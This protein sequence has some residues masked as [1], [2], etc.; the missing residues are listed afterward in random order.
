MAG[1]AKKVPNMPVFFDPKQLTDA[2]RKNWDAAIAEYARV[3][4]TNPGYALEQSAQDGNMPGG[5]IMRASRSALFAR[6]LEGK[7]ALPHPPPT[8][9]AHPWYAVIEEPGPHQVRMDGGIDGRTLWL[10]QCA[11]T[12]RHMNHAARELWELDNV[13]PSGQWSNVLLS[14]VKAAYAKGPE[15][16]VQYEP[17]PDYRLYVAACQHS[18]TQAVRPYA[19]DAVHVGVRPCNLTGS[20]FDVDELMLNAKLGGDMADR[21]P[22][23]G[24]E[25][26]VELFF[27]RWH[28]EKVN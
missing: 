18:G 23:T 27:D 8:R 14:K 9:Y 24:V 3:Q 22:N 20:V 7:P 12:I 6:L 25:D 5:N 17:W 28:L 13:R 10:D 11:W 4:K 1:E 16:V 26:W 21:K 2:Q 15:L 19:L